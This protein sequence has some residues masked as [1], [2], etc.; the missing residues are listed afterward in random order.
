M[1][2][3]AL[4]TRMS[5]RPNFFA[6]AA[7][8]ARHDSAEVTSTA[9]A[10]ALAPPAVSFLTAAAL[11]ASSRPA[12]MTAAPAS[13]RPCAMPKPIPPLPPVTTATRPPRS[14]SAIASSDRKKIARSLGRGGTFC[15]RRA[16]GE[17]DD[18]KHRA[19]AD[20]DRP[21]AQFV[22]APAADRDAGRL[23]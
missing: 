4:L 8:R 6:A 3:P 13:A 22:D 10:A 16:E 15:Q 9:M 20:E 1:L 12:T 23:A 18:E 7:M 21:V 11:F 2:V 14:K 5:S 19:G 17:G